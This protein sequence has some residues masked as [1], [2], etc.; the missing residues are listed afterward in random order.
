MKK[1]F[2]VTLLALVMITFLMVSCVQKGP[3]VPAAPDAA[4]FEATPGIG[5]IQLNWGAVA[6]ATFYNIVIDL[7]QPA[8]ERTS[9]TT[10]WEIQVTNPPYT[11]TIPYAGT[12][13]WTVAAGNDAGTSNPVAGAL[14]LFPLLAFEATGIS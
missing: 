4:T 10:H 3:A 9:E 14:R 1:R 8:G 7:V 12:F 13:S 6:G 11:W 2:W 5:V